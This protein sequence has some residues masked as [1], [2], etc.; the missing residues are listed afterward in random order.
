MVGK[1]GTEKSKIKMAVSTS[2][3]TAINL[4]AWESPFH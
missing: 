1:E 2:F 4:F 3:D